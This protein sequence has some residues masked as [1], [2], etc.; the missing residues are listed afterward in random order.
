M[1]HIAEYKIVKPEWEIYEVKGEK[2]PKSRMTKSLSDVVNENIRDGW[3]PIGGPFLP[4]SE[5]FFTCQAMVKYGKPQRITK[6]V[7]NV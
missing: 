6:G 5:C 4:H 2:E 1:P 3:K 7:G